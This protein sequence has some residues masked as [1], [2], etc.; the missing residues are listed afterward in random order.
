DI[1]TGVEDLL[2]DNNLFIYPNPAINFVNV[3]STSNLQYIEIYSIDGQLMKHE[4]VD[5]TKSKINVSD[6]T[7]GTYILRAAN[8]SALL[9][10]K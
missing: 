1:I 7:P 10:K 4:S 9:I 2:I 5:A 3:S 8:Q 6:L